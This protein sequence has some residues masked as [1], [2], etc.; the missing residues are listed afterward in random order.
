M[1]NKKSN[2]RLLSDKESSDGDKCQVDEIKSLM[3]IIARGKQ[4]EID[5]K[6]TIIDWTNDEPDSSKNMAEKAYSSKSIYITN[7]ASEQYNDR[8]KSQK[9]HLI[10]G[11]NWKNHEHEKDDSNLKEI[12]PI[13]PTKIGQPKNYS[14]S[15]KI[16][17]QKNVSGSEWYNQ[18]YNPRTPLSSTERISKS[19][20]KHRVNRQ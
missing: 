6:D 12:F 13:R 16:N 2:K 8:G 4:K 18:T 3:M 7:S 5:I 15:T 17:Q 11:L 1:P 20:K 9:E 19:K 14:D 10:I